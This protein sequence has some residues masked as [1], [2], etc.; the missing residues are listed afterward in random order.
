MSPALSIGLGKRTS[1]LVLDGRTA[2]FSEDSQAVYELNAS[3]T[4]ILKELVEPSAIGSV[5]ADLGAMLPGGHD[6][7]ENLLV[8][9]SRAGLIDVFENADGPRLPPDRR[10]GFF[11]GSK[12][13]Y[14]HGYGDGLDWLDHF[15]HGL[16]ADDNGPAAIIWRVAGLGI[17]KFADQPARLVH[18]HQLAAT[19]RFYLVETML[20]QTGRIAMH[21]A[22]LALDNRAILLL[23]GPGFGK[24]TLAM[25]A[26]DC[27]LSLRGD[28]IA[29]FDIN[30]CTITP[31]ALPLTLKKGSWP[32]LSASLQNRGKA[33]FSERQDGVC[34]QYLAI[35]RPVH[36]APLEISAMIYVDRT[37]SGSA[38]LFPWPKTD[39][40]R[41]LC[42]ESRS[43]SGKASVADIGA[44]VTAIS[45]A[46]TMRIR[47]SDA[48]EAGKLLGRHFGR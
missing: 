45:T 24:S 23:G 29:L 32:M 2:I 1:F 26:D 8:E 44:F 35:N 39:C 40:L 31:I 14:I 11:N 34:V 42:S 9:W 43:P 15:D 13:A 4:G 17:I 41:H 22:C 20:R 7:L 28:D 3:A 47:Y 19:L 18:R 5:Y 33:V 48:A 27:G 10:A 37:E 46:Q 36:D 6:E 16:V 12:V 21:C 38:R 30:A 25:F